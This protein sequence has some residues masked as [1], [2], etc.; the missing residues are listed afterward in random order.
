MTTAIT[1]LATPRWTADA[2]DL[3][4]A[5]ASQREPPPGVLHGILDDY[6]DSEE[7]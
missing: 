3:G 1:P 2:E 5:E 7:H 6:I 4:A